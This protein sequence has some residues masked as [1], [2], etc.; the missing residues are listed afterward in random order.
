MLILVAFTLILGIYAN[1]ENFLRQKFVG[2]KLSN[3][4][5]HIYFQ[6]L[7]E[8]VTLQSK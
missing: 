4:S 5:F 7:G 3:V 2:A 6:I 1:L 8:L